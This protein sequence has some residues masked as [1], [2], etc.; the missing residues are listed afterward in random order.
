[1]TDKTM[2]TD[3]L[4]ILWM[5]IALPLFAACGDDGDNGPE[6]EKTT[7]TVLVYMVADNTLGDASINRVKYDYRDLD[8]M[9]AALVANDLDHC[10]ILVYHSPAGEEPSLKLVTADGVQVLK[11]YDRSVY[12]VT[13]GRMK[14][15]F[16]DMRALCPADRYGLVL[17]SHASGWMFN[18][19]ASPVQGRSW[20]ID[21]GKEMSIPSLAEALSGE[22]FGYIYFDCCLMGN[23]ETLYELRGCAPWIVASPTETPL[24]G[25]PYDLNIPLLAAADP[26]LAGAA[27]NTFSY[28]NNLPSAGDRSIA[29]SV[30]DMSAIDRLANAVNAIYTTNMEMP[31]G[32]APQQYCDLTA[33]RRKFYDIDHYIKSLTDDP[34]LISEFDAAMA[35]FVV[36]HENTE[37]MWKNQ[38]YSVR[39]ENCAGL[40]TFIYSDGNSDADRYNYRDL[41][42]FMDVVP[43]NDEY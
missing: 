24:D 23:I 30:Y 14:E 40:S 1:M 9:Q 19:N 13:V 21:R 25:M 26:D 10:N 32:F 42:W 7:R 8:E 41:R 36:Y 3:I 16:S 12:S 38:S 20:G 22:G 5:L 35:G 2:K 39:L 43:H 17:W 27:Y 18:N 29:I 31:A 33:Y 6:P 37:Y 11:L 34:V 4:K 28:Y 15:V